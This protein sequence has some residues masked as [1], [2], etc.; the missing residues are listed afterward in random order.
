MLTLSNCGGLGE[1]S[2][3]SGS[4]YSLFMKYPTRMNSWALYEH[5]NNTTVTPIASFSGI[6][7]TFGGSAWNDF[8]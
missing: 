3:S 7:A 8:Y 4:L 6:L 2:F 5:V 1:F